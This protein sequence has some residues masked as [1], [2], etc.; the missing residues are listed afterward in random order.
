MR[1]ETR[2]QAIVDAARACFLQFGYAKTSLDDIAKRANISRPL[3]YRKFRNKEAVFGAVYDATFDARYPAADRVMAGP[4][5]ARDKLLRV[6]EAVCVDAWAL[7]AGTPM[8]DEFYEA[9]MQVV[10]EIVAKHERK[11]LGYTKQLLGSTAVAEVFMLA[12]EGLMLDTP[13]VAVFHRRL[14]VLVDRF[15]PAAR[16]GRSPRRRVPRM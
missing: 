12:V 6:Y 11:R 10:P 16:A 7:L 1:D 3:I 15:A 2:R 4:G 14:V 8:V 9:C 5:S 13:T